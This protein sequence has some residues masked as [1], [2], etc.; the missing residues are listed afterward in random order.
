MAKVRW[1]FNPAGFAEL[2]NHPLLVTAMESAA[3]TAAGG[4]SA[5]VEVVVWPHQGIKTGPRTSVQIW[6]D[7][8][9]DLI[10]ILSRVRI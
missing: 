7:E 10:G 3:D 1:K 9:D 6:G 8:P 2:R 4:T 5:S